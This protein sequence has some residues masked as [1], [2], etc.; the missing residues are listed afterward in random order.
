M[1]ELREERARK[2]A[3]MN[4]IIPFTLNEQTQIA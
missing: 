2:I 1:P 3:E 4:D